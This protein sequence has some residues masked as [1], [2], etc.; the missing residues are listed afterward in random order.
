MQIALK[1]HMTSKSVY[2]SQLWNVAVLIAWAGWAAGIALHKITHLLLM[3]LY[4]SKIHAH[5][6]YSHSRA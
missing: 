4:A 1:G 6:L 3:A 2:T 5:T